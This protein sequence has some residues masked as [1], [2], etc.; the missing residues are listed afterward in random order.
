EPGDRG[1]V[2]AHPALEGVLELGGVDREGLQLAEDVR[3]PEADEA[4]APLVDDRGNVVGGQVLVGHGVLRSMFQGSGSGDSSWIYRA[5]AGVR[6]C[7][8]A[9]RSSGSSSQRRAHS[10]SSLSA[11]LSARPISVRRYSTCTG[12]PG[13]TV[14][15]TTP[16][17]SSSFMRSDRSRAESS[18]TARGVA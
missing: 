3:E 9:G 2:E 18:G 11:G 16:R 5:A 15:S 17:A 4:D 1:A 12:G 6:A 13:S 8:A 10:R 14:R 7:R